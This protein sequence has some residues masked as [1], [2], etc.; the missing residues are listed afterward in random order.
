MQIIPLSNN[1]CRMRRNFATLS[2]RT[3]VQTLRSLTRGN[4]ER[5]ESEL[6]EFDSHL[7]A[8]AA[9]QLQLSEHCP[10]PDQALDLIAREARDLSNADG[11]AIAIDVD[12]EVSCRAC[13]GSLAP[14][15][16]TPVY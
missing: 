16:G 12:G 8:I 3:D 15:I 2:T 9:L 10:D 6:V 5:I 7:T 4:R 11:C 1:Y 13:A 14:A